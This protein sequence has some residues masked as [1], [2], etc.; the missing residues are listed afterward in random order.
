MSATNDFDAIILGGGLAGLTL[1]LQLKRHFAD[2][3]I[4][5]LERN[6]HP[7][8]EAAHKVGESTVE[9]GAHYLA[10]TLGLAEH[11]DRAHLRKFGLRYFF[12]H[13]REHIEQAVELGV[14][15]HLPLP[16]Y[17]LDRG[18]L[19]NF[20]GQ[21]ARRRGIDFR[22]GCKVRHCAVGENG[23]SHQVEFS[24]GE[25]SH[26]VDCRWLLDTSGRSA[27]LKRQLGLAR[28][29]EHAAHAAWF[30]LDGHIK[31]DDFVDDP[32]WRQ[33]CSP[34]DRWL[35]TN[36]LM[37]P[38]Y[39]VWLIPLGSGATSIGI[40]ADSS[41]H[42]L[43]EMRDFDS[44]LKWL[45]R[46]QPALAQRIEPLSG[47]VLDFRFLRK[48]SHSATQVFSADRWALS[49]EA[50]VFLDPF[51]SPGTDFIA[52]ANHYITA[53]IGIDRKGQPID[54][55][56][57]IFQDLYLS[58]YANTMSLYQDQYPLF[59]NARVMAQKITWDYSYYWGI[60][61]V[62]V[63]QNRL[64][65]I[66]LLGDVQAQLQQ[67]NA[68]NTRMQNLFSRWHEACADDAGARPGL[69]DQGALDWFVEI[70]RQ[71]TDLTDDAGVRQRIA[72]HL[73]LLHGL[74]DAIS[75]QASESDSSLAHEPSG[76]PQPELLDIG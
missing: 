76:A 6:A 17:Q 23:A 52:I 12:S 39:W 53:L 37:G 14:T 15:R 46:N 51:Y 67:A 31:I 68:L 25:S 58:F 69:A 54:P 70:N 48:Y 42:S 16:S 43:D 66:A 57:R 28:D 19:E 30:R 47:K 49:G 21:E 63:F 9:I 65:D 11:I 13:G 38:G 35:S 22:D 45:M 55:W 40:V 7:L 32:T 26:T 41:M 24:D 34:P 64:T 29:N 60:L 8:P 33:Q 61:C 4:L 5:V 59:G 50:G 1:A 3:R 27:L 44:A 75:A 74:A 20:L 71:M 36:H 72:D 62:L 10:E 56:V 2:M 73:Q 18:I